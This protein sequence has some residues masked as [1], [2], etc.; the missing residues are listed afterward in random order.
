M[1]RIVICPRLAGTVPDSV[2]QTQLDGQKT[3]A[4]VWRGGMACQA[5]RWA[6]T[7]ASLWKQGKL[8]YGLPI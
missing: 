7:A 5:G 3:W 6:S 2:G 4:R 8:T 1:G